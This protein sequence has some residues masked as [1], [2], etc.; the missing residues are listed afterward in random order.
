MS[1]YSHILWDWNG[2]LLDDVRLCIDIVNGM[3]VRRSRPGIDPRRYK[4]IF[5]FPVRGYYE[6]A[7]FD[8]SQETFESACTEFCGEYERRA[9]E[10][11]LYKNA[12]K[13]LEGYAVR[14]IRQFV[15]STTEQS[16]LE[17][18]VAAFGIAPVFDRVVGQAD[19][20]A[21][22]KAARAVELLAALRVP[23]DEILL[24]GDTTHD[25]DVARDIGVDCVLVS[26]GH[27]S[28]EKLLQTGAR[29]VVQLSHIMPAKRNS[30]RP[31]RPVE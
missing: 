20:Y 18:M 23:A 6:R 19:H 24:V 7:G 5:G 9:G 15:L 31:R 8:F 3:L 12:Q 30:P 13:I 11:R 1:V 2:T 22:G 28:H 17:A 25:A 26:S 14:G 4:S 29:V 27:H 10:C 21:T 16:R